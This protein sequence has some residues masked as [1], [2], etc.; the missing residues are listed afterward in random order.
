ML[1]HGVNPQTSDVYKILQ[2]NISMRHVQ[3]ETQQMGRSTVT[4]NYKETC[5]KYF[6]TYIFNAVIHT[7]LG[8]I[9]IAFPLNR[10]DAWY[11]GFCIRWMYH[12]RIE[13]FK[14]VIQK[15]ITNM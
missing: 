15:W 12:T 1:K 13:Y 5:W 3:A 8:S 7:G 10:R 2:F 9:R 11:P 14:C 6:D 4:T